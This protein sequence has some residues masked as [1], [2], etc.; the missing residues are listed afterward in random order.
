LTAVRRQRTDLRI[1]REVRSHWKL[2]AAI[3]VPVL[4]DRRIGT[5]RHRAARLIL[6]VRGVTREHHVLWHHIA[7]E[8][9]QADAGIV[10]D[11][12]VD[13]HKG[14]R[15]LN[16]PGPG[17]GVSGDRRVDQVHRAAIGDG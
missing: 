16:A 11:R 1:A 7:T 14:A 4:L 17:R 15:E 10:R 2:A 12:D 3:A 6:A 13:H 5:Y 8:P 9:D